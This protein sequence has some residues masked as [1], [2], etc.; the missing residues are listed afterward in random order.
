MSLDLTDVRDLEFEGWKPSA[1]IGEGASAVVFRAT[2][3]DEQAA[4]KIFRPDLVQKYGEIVQ[5]ARIERQLRMKELAHPNLI[6]V[7]S[8]GKHPGGGLY[9]LA[10]EYLPHQTLDKLVSRVFPHRI[11]PILAQL[12]AAARFLEDHGFAH[13]DIKPENIALDDEFRTAVLLDFGVLLPLAGSSVT[14]Q[15]TGQSFFLGTT[16]YSPPEFLTRREAR[17][18]EAYRAITFYQLGAVLHDMLTGHR[19]FDEYENEPYTRLTNAVQHEKPS[20]AKVREGVDSRL[21]DL[22]ERCLTKDPQERLRLVSWESFSCRRF[23]RR[24]VVVLLYTGGTIGAFVR[25]DPE[26]ERDLRRISSTSDPFLQ[27]FKEKIIRDHS[28][29][30]GPSSPFP[31]DLEWELL[32]PEQQLLSENAEYRTWDNLARAI[33]VI[34]K[35]YQCPPQPE[36]GGDIEAGAD[37]EPLKYL[38]G[39]V[40][41]HGTDTLAYSAAALA[42]SLQNL[43]CPIVLTG[44]NQP[45]NVDDIFEQDPI[46]SRS[47]AWRNVRR[48]LLY[49]QA[50]GHRFTEVGV[51]F[52]DT[53][54]IAINLRKTST[55]RQPFGREVEDV[56]LQEPY[57]YRN[58]GRQ[59]QYMFRVIEENYCNNFYPLDSD[60]D[61][62]VFLR[63]KKNS[64]RHFRE[65]LLW[66]NRTLKRLPFSP[67]V[68]LAHISPIFFPMPPQSLYLSER[69][70][71]DG[72]E[73]LV[74]EGYHSGTFPTH[75]SHP[76]TDLL[77]KLIARAIP[78]VLVTRTGLIPTTQPYEM[79]KVDGIDLPVV[80][81]FGIIAETAAP[82]ISVIRATI[83]EEEWSPAEQLDPAELLRHRVS[84]LETAIRRWQ[85]ESKGILSAL[86]GSIVDRVFQLQR[87]GNGVER[88]RHEFSNMVDSLFRG[89]ASKSAAQLAP[90][91]KERQFD[92]TKTILMREHFLW[93]LVEILRPFELAGIGPDGLATLNEMGFVWGGRIFDAMK[94]PEP[95]SAGGIFEDQIPARRKE[96]IKRA[97]SKVE[98]LSKTIRKHG[99]ADVKTN[100]T[101][102]GPPSEPNSAEN[103]IALEVTSMRHGSIVRHDELFGAA[104]YSNEE[105]ALFQMLREGADLTLYHE[106]CE[107]DMEKRLKQLFKNGPGMRLS[108]LDWFLLGTFK[109]TMCRILRDLSFDTWVKQCNG[110]DRNSILALRQS[111]V[112]N[113]IS[114]DEHGWRAELTYKRRPDLI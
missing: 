10:M 114:S 112:T 1:H 53:V 67:G 31:F 39:I 88:D 98:R 3:D 27:R 71:L 49:L 113:V 107:A 24:P 82:L 17:I 5:A 40:V 74:L 61:Y 19:M 28:L 8:G 34:C 100:L 54:H 30:S 29:I 75:P 48:C 14:D 87:L 15:G 45:P 23:A 108:T 56:A 110:G 78:I 83:P 102:T 89:S 7:L 33:E 106:Q 93:I 9:Y 18:P 13:R 62:A 12:A 59:R 6:R 26:H 72:L 2:K 90:E 85:D 63:D 81:L 42:V 51:C 41:L 4:L 55:N 69:E 20:F 99:V 79:D 97:Q 109:A 36:T 92:P 84:L 91:S 95:P 52:G 22:A 38:A 57:L 43:P 64:Y 101:I 58:E 44:S 11:A 103:Q 104:G 77:R 32:P 46:D 86:L 66:T 35:K 80:R 70:E 94:A 111:V 25:D 65:S 105:R 73:V 50:F 60:L 16:R 37:G 21:V 96:M 68:R 47:D 76:F